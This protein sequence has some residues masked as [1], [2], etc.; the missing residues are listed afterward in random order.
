MGKRILLYF[1]VGLLIFFLLK[2]FFEHVFPKYKSTNTEVIGMVGAYTID[3]LPSDIINKISKGLTTI[4]KDGVAE[5]SLAKSWRIEENGKKYIFYLKENA[6]FSDKENLTSDLINYGFSDVEVERPG[7]Y[8]IIF[9]LKNAYSPFLVSVSKP[10]FK[11]GFVGVGDYRAK[12]LKLNGSFIESI[13]LVSLDKNKRLVYQFYPTFTALKTAFVLGDVTKILGLPDVEFKNTTFY[14]FKN[15]RVKKDVNY[16]QL[17]TLFYN[18]RDENLSS[19][20]LREALSYTIFD[21]FDQGERSFGP[22][23]PFSFVAQKGLNVYSQDLDHA[24]L[25]LEKFRTEAPNANLAFV[26]DSLPQY[27]MVAENTAKAWNKLG[28]ETKVNE[29]GKPP[30]K[31]QIFLGEFFL[32]LDPDQYVLWHSDHSNNI[33]GYKN[34][35]IDKLLEDGRQT[36]DIEERKKIYF[37]FQKYLLADAPA[38]FLFFPY[39]YE[40]SRN[41]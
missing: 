30:S 18:T 41:N 27:R 29:V 25:L 13:D 7:K 26:I 20:T 35:R 1:A 10:I 8:T 4:R 6:Y 3:N 17:V 2:S 40:V 38:S 11:K 19:K 34:L 24:K 22:Y 31:F 16:R 12:K 28:I 36:F 15:A 23:A 37:D 21:T 14:E 32:S 33:A 39:T 5:A 9:K